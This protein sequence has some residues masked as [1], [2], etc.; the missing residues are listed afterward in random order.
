MGC[1]LSKKIFTTITGSTVNRL[2]YTERGWLLC[3]GPWQ[4]FYPLSG[5]LV[6]SIFFIQQNFPPIF[7]GPPLPPRPPLVPPLLLLAR[8]HTRLNILPPASSTPPPATIGPQD[9]VALAG[10]S[11]SEEHLPQLRPVF[12][13]DLVALGLLWKN[14]ISPSFVPQDLVALGLLYSNHIDLP[15]QLRPVRS[16][17][18][19]P[20]MEESHLPQLRPA[21]PGRAGAFVEEPEGA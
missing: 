7:P 3:G 6:A 14:H 15:H 20:F 2:Y 4:Y 12:D 18:V 9:R 11:C 13:Q 21:R 17:R 1:C 16:G 5:T 19:R 8:F 10:R